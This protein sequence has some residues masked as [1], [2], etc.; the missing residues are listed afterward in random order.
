MLAALT[1]A[2]GKKASP[3]DEAFKLAEAIKGPVAS[4]QKF[5]KDILPKDAK[6]ENGLIWMR[7]ATDACQASRDDAE[8]LTKLQ[9][10]PP[11]D[12][13]KSLADVLRLVADSHVT[14]IDDHCKDSVLKAG[15]FFETTSKCRRA[16]IK[17]WSKLVEILSKESKQAKSNYGVDFPAI[18]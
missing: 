5:H 6:A 17:S 3:A 13:Q 18:D 2:C 11:L 16:C 14:A 15:D 4:L 7:A 1:A 10:D 8:R 12:A 9:F